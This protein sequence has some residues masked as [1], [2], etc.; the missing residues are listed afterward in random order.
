M[1][2][3]E[4]QII[5]CLERRNGLLGTNVPG[6]NDRHDSPATSDDGPPL[7]GS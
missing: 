1:P 4:I 5:F 6:E 3:A 2:E 7:G